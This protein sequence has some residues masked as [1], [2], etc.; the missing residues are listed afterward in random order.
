MLAA[1]AD[2][3]HP[4]DLAARVASAPADADVLEGLALLG[5]EAA[6]APLEARVEAE[7]GA[8]RAAASRALA[9]ALPAGALD[10]WEAGL[11]KQ[12]SVLMKG[13]PSDP[14]IAAVTA[15]TRA[16]AER[17]SC[18]REHV[19]AAIPT[20]DGLDA[21]LTAARAAVTE[22]DA[23]ARDA[24]AADASRAQELA[25]LSAGEGD[26]PKPTAK[27]LADARFELDAIQKRR[28]AV[29]AAVAEATQR[30]DALT[31]RLRAL[32]VA[33]RRALGPAAAP[34]AADLA[35]LALRVVAA[36]HGDACPPARA[37]AAAALVDAASPPDPAALDAAI[38][39]N[40][41]DPALAYLL[42]T[43]R[44]AAPE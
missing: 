23:K 11:A 19:E 41:D 44:A 43:L 2:G 30:A 4:D 20:L 35:P 16:C 42:M 8:S 39:A 36:C 21:E 12:A 24:V 7:K 37:F 17:A 9:L 13:I 38:T 28:D 32:V 14:Q 26:G 3:G 29:Y 6:V 10:A 33:L 5:G 1:G 27:E 34:E 15:L 22:A 31:A 25:R 18:Y 40:A